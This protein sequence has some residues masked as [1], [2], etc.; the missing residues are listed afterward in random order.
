VDPAP[1]EPEEQDDFS[2]D[3]LRI[4]GGH[5]PDPA[6]PPPPEPAPLPSPPA[7]GPQPAAGGEPA[8][9]A[10]SHAVFDR[11][12]EDLSLAR[13]YDYGPVSLAQRFDELDRA[14]D[15]QDG[16]TRRTAQRAEAARALS[17]HDERLDVAGIV[18]ER[19]R[20]PLASPPRPLQRLVHDV[21]LVGA[22]D[23]LTCWAAAA[24]SLVAWRDA[25]TPTAEAVAAGEGHWAP[26]AAVRTARRPEDLRA[27]G[28]EVSTVATDDAGALL[29]TLL[30]ALQAHGPL[31]VA[32]SP[33][34]AHA[35]VVSG[36]TSDGTPDGT[37][38]TVLDPCAR[39]ATGSAAPVTLPALR[40]A[41]GGLPTAPLTVAHVAP[42]ARPSP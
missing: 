24:A 40:A 3:L 13:T 7:A 26:F 21:D 14:M 32:A 9:T 5:R 25:V 22:V 37:V 2:Q 28:V 39:D 36:A 31:W 41:V 15:V 34:G 8:S 6:V 38:L 30:G 16:R 35:I 29:G 20:P 18:G 1:H 42:P 23:G 12:G 19:G 33:P 4:L 11:L 17:A 27:W 10:T